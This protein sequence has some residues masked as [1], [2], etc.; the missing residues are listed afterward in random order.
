LPEDWE[1]SNYQD[2]MDLRKGTLVNRE[3]IKNNFGMPKEYRKLVM[4]FI[5]TKDLP[6]DMREYLYE[7]EN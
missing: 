5:E 1:F 3:F 4:D 7:L 6:G 2:W